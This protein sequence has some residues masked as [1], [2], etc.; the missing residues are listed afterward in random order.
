MFLQAVALILGLAAGPIQAEMPPPPADGVA[1]PVPP[2][3]EDELV[4]GDIDAPVTIIAYTSL[5]CRNCAAWHE[6]VLPR[7]IETE[8]A[9]GRA[10]LVYRQLPTDPRAISEVATGIVQCA[11]REN[12]MNVAGALFDAQQTMID[13]G[14]V[15]DWYLAGIEAS[16]RNRTEI[17]ACLADPAT[18]PALRA[19]RASGIAAGVTTMPEFFVNGSLVASGALDHLQRATE[20]AISES[21]TL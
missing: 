15:M 13:G 20:A 12:R 16:G 21:P 8:I 1:R 2:V 19:V 11:V 17:E 18:I 14:P 5:V 9:T 7:I 10:R 4:L 3:T 6:E